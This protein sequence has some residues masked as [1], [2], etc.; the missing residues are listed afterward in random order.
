MLEIQ[1]LRA[2]VIEARVTS[3]DATSEVGVI[4]DEIF[5]NKTAC[6]CYNPKVKDVV[7]G[8][9]ASSVYNCKLA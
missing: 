4:D 6:H 7:S 3:W 9:P 2:K 5:F 1:T 8:V